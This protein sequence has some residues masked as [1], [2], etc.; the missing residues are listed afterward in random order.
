MEKT[1]FIIGS[2]FAGFCVATGAFGAHGLK[3]LVPPKMLDTWDKA[4]RYQIYHALGLLV[5]A[6][7]IT[8][9]PS[10]ARSFVLGGGLFLGGIILFSGSLYLLVLSGTKWL[11]AI[12][13][14]GGAAFVA[15]WLCMLLGSWRG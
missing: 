2:V 3:K 12:T 8:Y 1:F 14:F 15:G 7:A 6:W 5:V 13:P 11:G 9:W 4:V 10:Q